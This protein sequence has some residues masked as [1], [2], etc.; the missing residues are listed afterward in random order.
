MSKAAD[1]AKVS[2]QGSFHYMWGLIVSTVIS[3]VGTIFIA[4]LLG[5]DLYGLY[6]IV[7]TIP[8]LIGIF[9][10]WGVNSAMIRFTAQYK[11][12]G[13]EAEVRSVF[14]SGLIFEIAV[15]LALSA[16]SIGV[17]PF[18]ADTIYNRPQIAPLIQIASFTIL[19]QGI[20]NA[21][22]AAFTGMEKIAHNSL[23][24]ICQSAIKTA[25]IIA[26]VI[27]GFST[28]GAVIG[29][30][31][32]MIIAGLIGGLLMWTLYKKLPKQTTHKSNIKN[33]IKILLT[34]GTPLSLAN[35][36]AGFQSNFFGFL[37][38]IF[39][40]NDNT[41]IGNYHIAT[42]FV[43]LITF[44]ATP[45]TSMLFPAFSKLN[46]KDDKETLKNVYQFSIRYASILVVPVAA[47][48]MTLAEP[49]VATLF[50]DTYGTAPLFLA[51][52][53]ITY[54]YTA[55]G[56]LTTGN[57]IISQ[58]KT[59]F[60]FHLT[61]LTTAIGIPVGYILIMTF[62][63]LGLIATTL[64]AGIPSLLISIFWIKK[65]YELT[66][67]WRSST[68]ILFASAIAAIPTYVLV[69]QLE[70]SNWIRLV[71]GAG[72]FIIV[73]VFAALFTRTVTRVDISNIRNMIS[74][75]GGLNRIISR[76]L[77]MIEK[78]IDVLRL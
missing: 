73:Y 22:T 53:S 1:M 54:F 10:D 27:A 35:I 78:M 67:D 36:I 59:K 19:A 25:V 66:V 38:P 29:H 28:S 11:A 33:Y 43:V 65:H 39:Y 42:T 15:G 4:R 41:I 31:T 14:I 58:G 71:I 30:A 49:A 7:L 51:L 76:L 74:G 18:L 23:M 5:S 47:L 68:K 44:F 72:F 48:V 8:S 2:A 34:F 45:I 32:A 20:V 64:I 21:A 50:G 75:I 40:L 57:F 26:L 62:G 55:T 17:S 9:R 46:P 63:V 3:S 16:V 12:E 37:L 56:S 70:V 6:G 69:S 61:A 60:I 24:L 13:R 52:L 77:D